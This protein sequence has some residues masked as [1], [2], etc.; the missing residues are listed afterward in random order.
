[1]GSLNHWVDLLGNT[2]LQIVATQ[3]YSCNNTSITINV[4]AVFSPES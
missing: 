3:S 1:M 2:E 4:S